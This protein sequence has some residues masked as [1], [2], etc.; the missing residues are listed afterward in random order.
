MDFLYLCHINPYSLN[1]K[2]PILYTM[3]AVALLALLYF[4]IFINFTMVVIG[5]LTAPIHCGGIL[6]CIIGVIV[7]VGIEILRRNYPIIHRTK[8]T[9]NYAYPLFSDQPTTDDKYDRTTSADVLIKK[10]FATFHTKQTFNG[11]FVVNINESYGSGKTSFLRIFEKQ[12]RSKETDYIFIDYRPWL[13]DN[14]QSIVNEFFTL[15][16]NEL[17][18]NDV[19]DDISNY[20]HLLLSQIQNNVPSW[21]KPF[22]AILFGKYS[23]KTLLEYHDSIKVSLSQI[24]RPI[25][26][27]IDDVDRLQEKEL[28]AV[29]KLIRDTADFPNIFYIVAAEN[30]HLEMMLSKMGIQNPNNYLKKFFNLDYLLPAHEGVPT[31]VLQNKLKT[32]LSS[33]DYPHEHIVSSLMMFQRLPNMDKAFQNIREVYRFLNAYTSSLDILSRNDTIHLINPYELFCLTLIRHL[34]LDVYKKLRDR[35]DEFLEVVN[36]RLDA[37]FH[38]KDDF[39]IERIQRNREI[40][41]HMDE[42]KSNKTSP[43]KRK[44]LQRE[45]EVQTLDEV[46]SQTEITRDKIVTIILDHLFGNV[47]SRD[48]RSICRCNVYFLYFSG[49]IESTKLTTA[50]SVDLLKMNQSAYE[51]ALSALF[52]LNKADAF[53]SNFSYAYHQVKISK[54][55]AMKKFYTFLKLQFKYNSSIDKRLFD[56]FEDFINKGYESFIYFLFELYGRDMNDGHKR[57][58]KATEDNLK[59]YCETE[60]DINML[61]L[62]FYLFSQRLGNFCFGREFVNPMLSSLA[63]RLINERMMKYDPIHGKDESIFNTMI[64][65]REEFATKEQW[66]TKFEQFLYGDENRCMQWL[67]SM[68]SFYSNGYI[69]WNYRHR[70]AII[71]EYAN[72]GDNLLE[73]MKQKYPDYIEIAE[74]L[75]HFQNYRSLSGITLTN[76]KYIQ[77]AREMHQVK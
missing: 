38:L 57:A 5:K 63:D 1:M 19:K 51:K 44:Q 50:E 76:S 56:T 68:V 66:E 60:Q 74:E 61:S 32:I 16:Q 21:I 17:P 20:L 59:A 45:T 65:F 24:D 54:E 64:L 8:E 52:N 75:K 43:E 71:G 42:A 30:A 36:R 77:M 39:N 46:I 4:N 6:L 23:G 27:T 13:C 35:N 53:I 47:D 72:S 34:R 67:G 25:I 28:T 55:N 70:V 2:K 3:Y 29:L 11:S 48:E 15:L 31:M 12:L 14:E 9:E 69:D 22:T 18:D 33:Y 40:T 49:K 41:Q 26:V 10:I 73:K 58:D 62:A 37:R 7:V